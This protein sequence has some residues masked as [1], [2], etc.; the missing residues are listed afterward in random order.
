M[1]ACGSPHVASVVIIARVH[2]PADE[3]TAAWMAHTARLQL[4][5]HRAREAWHREQAQYWAGVLQAATGGDGARTEAATAAGRAESDAASSV[6]DQWRHPIASAVDGDIRISTTQQQPPSRDTTVGMRRSDE[7][8]TGHSLSA[9]KPIA[10]S[11]SRGEE[12]EPGRAVEGST[13]GA[14]YPILSSPMRRDSELSQQ[15]EQALERIERRASWESQSRGASPLPRAPMPAS[16]S[17]SSSSSSSFT[18]RAPPLQHLTLSRPSISRQKGPDSAGLAKGSD[19][20]SKR[21][22]PHGGRGI[23]ASWFGFTKRKAEVSG[24]FNV[25]KMSTGASVSN[26]AAAARASSFH[27]SSSEGGSTD[28]PAQESVREYSRAS[29]SPQPSSTKQSAAPEQQQKQQLQYQQQQLLPPVSLAQPGKRLSLGQLLNAA[30]ASPNSRSSS[31]HNSPESTSSNDSSN[32]YAVQSQQLQQHPP[33]YQSQT[34]HQSTQP[35]SLHKPRSLPPTP[36]VSVSAPSSR[37]ASPLRILPGEAAARQA[38][39]EAASQQLAPPAQAGRAFSPTL[40]P[41]LGTD[42][43]S[44]AP[45]ASLA[46]KKHNWPPGPPPLLSQMSQQQYPSGSA[47][48]SAPL[49]S[50]PSLPSTAPA[51]PFSTEMSGVSIGIRQSSPPPLPPFAGARAPVQARSQSQP[52]SPVLSEAQAASARRALFEQSVSGAAAGTFAQ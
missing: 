3:R 27:A 52:S 14:L 35:P 17:S 9:S 51:S 18:S 8:D 10:Q 16:S 5:Q 15:Q 37:S 23:L 28:A 49:Q 30:Q 34:Q 19:G 31:A 29:A 39:R 6:V 38:A 33:Q 43:S 48:P 21:T 11:P 1:S 45:D 50:P 47:S 46:G 24:P 42:G 41:H 40:P 13:D 20:S 25:R 22:K 44:S 12:A 26:V 7:S 36:Y 4:A 2:C 32:A